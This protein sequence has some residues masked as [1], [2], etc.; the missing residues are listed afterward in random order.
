MKPKTELVHHRISCS[1]HCAVKA[2]HGN[3]YP[4]QC[5]SGF[6][7]TV[8]RSLASRFLYRGC[9][10][11]TTCGSTET[12]GINSDDLNFRSS[13]RRPLHLAWSVPGYLLAGL[14]PCHHLCMYIAV[15]APHLSLRLVYSAVSAICSVAPLAAALIALTL[16]YLRGTRI[17]L[18]REYHRFIWQR[19]V[20]AIV[21]S[22]LLAVR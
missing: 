5:R 13:A 1:Q 7:N 10:S 16:L 11:E 6:N 2:S 22:R 18:Q 12:A 3:S 4:H 21:D 15:S 19:I 14:H 20:N 8:T 9:K 17:R